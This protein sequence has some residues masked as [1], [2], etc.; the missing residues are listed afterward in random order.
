MDELNKVLGQVPPIVR[1]EGSA[2]EKLEAIWRILAY[3]RRGLQTRVAGDLAERWASRHE[4]P[5]L[6]VDD[7]RR[8]AKRLERCLTGETSLPLDLA[9]LFIECLPEPFR[10]AAKVMVFPRR[11]SAASDL[12]EILSLDQAHDERTDRL[13]FALATGQHL[14]MNAEQLEAAALAFDDDSTSS[15]GLASAL[16]AMASNKRSGVA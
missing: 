14:A 4:S 2:R 15:R 8:A 16:R 12:M 6:P 13:R 5:R 9:M 3:G 1:E 7:P 10:T 11:R